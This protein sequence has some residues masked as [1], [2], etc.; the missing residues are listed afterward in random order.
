[1]FTVDF[2]SD[3]KFS[4]DFFNEPPPN[5]NPLIGATR[6]ETTENCCDLQTLIA[7]LET[8]EHSLLPAGAGYGLY[9]T[10][11]CVKNALYFEDSYRYCSEKI[12][13]LINSTSD[14][15]YFASFF[16]NPP[17][18]QSPVIG[19]NRGDT[20]TNCSDLL[21]LIAHLET[22]EEVFATDGAGHGLYLMIACANNALRFENGYRDLI[23]AHSRLGHELDNLESREEHEKYSEKRRK[24]FAQKILNAGN[25]QL[26]NS[27]TEKNTDI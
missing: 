5:Q 21:T 22:N 25:Y 19:S 26:N 27:D 10:M 14:P 4:T 12:T 11:E 7:H 23:E 15:K 20:T 6:R 13:E 24:D 9:L 17:P 2:N 16:D 1:M 8:N 3:H 18:N